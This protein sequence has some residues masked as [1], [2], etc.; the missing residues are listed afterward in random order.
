MNA[1][2]TLRVPQSLHDVLGEQTRRLDLA[3][4]VLAGAVVAGLFVHQMDLGDIA[5]WRVVLSVALVADIAA[6]A[7][8][9]LTQGTNDYYVERPGHRWA[10]IAIHVHVLLVAWAVDAPLSQAVAL[11]AFTVLSASVVNVRLSKPSASSLAGTLVILGSAGVLLWQ[12]SGPPAL[13][14]VYVLF[15]FKVVFSFAVDHHAAQADRCR[16]GVHPLS[17]RDQDAF[18]SL[19]AAAFSDDPLFVRLFPASGRNAQAHRRS[20]A[21]FV[22]DLNR[23]FGGTPRGLFINGQLVAGWLL[24]PPLP[25]CRQAVASGLA[26]VRGVPLLARLGPS[27]MQWLNEYTRRTRAVMPPGPHHYLVMLGVHPDYQGKGYGGTALRTIAAEVLDSDGSHG[28]G[29]DT[30][31]QSNVALYERFGY[32][33][34]ES[35]VLD[36]QVTAYCMVRPN[37]G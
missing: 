17:P 22:L 29:L 4:I 5:G 18:S 21:S 15:L 1:S 2:K 20:F 11:W 8:A 32:R 9:N 33:R 28:V 6:G 37:Q 34:L 10:F 31:K 26:V 19:I 27:R 35:Q 24:D 12:P 3:L 13:L 16:N 7:V 23:V 14:L 36:E 30:E 25:R